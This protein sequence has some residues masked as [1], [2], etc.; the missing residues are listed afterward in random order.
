MRQVGVVI[1]VCTAAALSC[2]DNKKDNATE[3]TA[4]ASARAQ[5][6]ASVEREAEPWFAGS[7]SASFESKAKSIDVESERAAPAQWQQDARQ[8]SALGPGTITLVVD[9][10]GGATATVRGALG[11]LTGVGLVEDGHLTVQLHPAGDGPGFRG[12]LRT[13]SQDDRAFVGEIRA[14]SADSLSVRQADVR[15]SKTTAA[16]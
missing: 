1:L 2:R 11:N 16:H 8:E 7:W 3:A 15:L 14:S 12:V 5:P 9:K 10:G 13:T 4:A 6:A